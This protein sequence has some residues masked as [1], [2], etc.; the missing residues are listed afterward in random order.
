MPV[1]GFSEDVV[2]HSMLLLF[3]MECRSGATSLELLAFSSSGGIAVPKF[4][5]TGISS[6]HRACRV[7]EK[8]RGW[9]R[10]WR[11]EG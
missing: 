2:V 3:V 7:I 6:K 9:E 4:L 10:V 1:T 8:E 11:E 5:S